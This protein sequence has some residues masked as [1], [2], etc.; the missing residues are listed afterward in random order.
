MAR[1]SM[2][3][4]LV[5]IVSGMVAWLLLGG[6]FGIVKLT[7]ALVTL[8]GLALTRC[9]GVDRAVESRQAAVEALKPLVRA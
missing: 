5:P 3:M 6:G 9:A 7:G 4:Y 2:F 1:I 8:G